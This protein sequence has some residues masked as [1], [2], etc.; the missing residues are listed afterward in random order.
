MGKYMLEGI[1][2]LQE[3]EYRHKLGS[4]ENK[5]HTCS[6]D[7]SGLKFGSSGL[8]IGQASGDDP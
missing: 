4:I 3:W 1:Y 6:G 2:A 7:G 5:L 8:F